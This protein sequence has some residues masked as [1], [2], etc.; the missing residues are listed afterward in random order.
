MVDLLAALNFALDFTEAEMVSVTNELKKAQ[1]GSGE[2]SDDLLAA[3]STHELMHL[4]QDQYE[5]AG[6]AGGWNPDR[7]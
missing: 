1:E 6:T 3:V 4:I 2:L 7:K 5:G